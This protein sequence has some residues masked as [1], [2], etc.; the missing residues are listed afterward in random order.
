M[1]KV[2]ID[3]GSNLDIRRVAIENGMVTL[4]RAALMNAARGITALP[5]VQRCTVGDE[6]EASGGH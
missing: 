5:E 6:E 1:R 2:V 3:G 4:R